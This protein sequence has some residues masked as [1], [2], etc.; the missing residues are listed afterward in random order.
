M[1]S[2][3]EMM[4]DGA[5][6]R[7]GVGWCVEKSRRGMV[8]REEHDVGWCVEKSATWQGTE[9]REERDVAGNGMSRRAGRVSWKEPDRRV[10]MARLEAMKCGASLRA[11]AMRSG[12]SIR[13]ARRG[14][15]GHVAKRRLGLVRAGVSKKM[16][17]GE[18]TRR[19]Q[20]RLVGMAGPGPS[21][22]SGARTTGLETPRRRTFPVL[23]TCRRRGHSLARRSAS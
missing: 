1:S 13:T 20:T 4:R 3:F 14:W 17:D 23:A 15:V 18:S 11:G 16:R 21:R 9:R 10:E 7:V 6:K 2:R 8:R 19:G 12:P 5:S 22:R